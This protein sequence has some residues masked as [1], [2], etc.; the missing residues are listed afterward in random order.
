[1]NDVGVTCVT[2][3][4]SSIEGSTLRNNAHGQD[5]ARPASQY[6]SPTTNTSTCNRLLKKQPTPSELAR[7]QPPP[8]GFPGGH[9]KSMASAQDDFNA[10][11]QKSS[12][13]TSFP[14]I[15]VHESP[16]LGMRTGSE[17]SSKL[18]ARP[19]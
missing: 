17:E 8:R 4:E 11:R 14:N 12:S 19:R 9:V 10:V 7:D 5:D 2:G 18:G 13:A 3:I 6:S 15:M 16:G 1:M